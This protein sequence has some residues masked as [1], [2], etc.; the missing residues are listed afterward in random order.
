MILSGLALAG[1][2]ASGVGAS[3]RASVGRPM[4]VGVAS[5]DIINEAT[6]PSTPPH[7]GHLLEQTP[8]DRMTRWAETRLIPGDERGNLLVTVRKASLTEE[9]L[10]TSKGVKALLKDEQSRLVRVEFEVAFSFSHPEGRRSATMTVGSQYER[11]IAESATA[12]EADR[13]RNSVLEEG[14]GSFDQEFRRQITDASGASGWPL[15]GR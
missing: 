6:S 3:V 10:A 9:S 7:I 4:T 13:V 11:S 1:C 8:G 15:V 2:G 12:A 5:I 14:L